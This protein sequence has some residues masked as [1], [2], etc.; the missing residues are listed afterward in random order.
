MLLLP[1]TTW[2]VSQELESPPE[3]IG[4]IHVQRRQWRN[5]RTERTSKERSIN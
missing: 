3:S 5:C 1:P 4:G 2:E